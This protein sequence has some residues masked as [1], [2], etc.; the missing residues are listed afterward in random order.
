MLI[1]KLCISDAESW[2]ASPLHEQSLIT[3]R[4]TY[5]TSFSPSH[6]RRPPSLLPNALKKPVTAAASGGTG[7]SKAKERSDG[8]RKRKL[9]ALEELRMVRDGGGVGD[10]GEGVRSLIYLA[11]G[12]VCRWR[13]T[14][15]R[16]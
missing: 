10:G 3:E 12:C 9:G 16:K 15:K 7:P 8:S 13:K 6:C 1:Y 11:C 14:G 2:R 4:S 5:I